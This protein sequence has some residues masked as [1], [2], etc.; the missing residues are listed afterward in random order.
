MYWPGGDADCHEGALLALA[1]PGHHGNTIGGQPLPYP[2]PPLLHAGSVAILERISQKHSVVQ[3]GD[4]LKTT[5]F[6]DREVKVS[7]LK[8]VQ[9][10]WA[11]T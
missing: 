1:R 5:A 6:G 4:G 9:C 8:G 11:P 7:D 3:V 2:V 10:P